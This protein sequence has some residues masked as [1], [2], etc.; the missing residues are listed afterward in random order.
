MAEPRYSGFYHSEER[1]TIGHV[2]TVFSFKDFRWQK[3]DDTYS[4]PAGALQVAF[5]VDIG[6]VIATLSSKRDDLGKGLLPRSLL[7]GMLREAEKYITLNLEHYQGDI[8]Y[9]FDFRKGAVSLGQPLEFLV[10]KYICAQ[11]E[12]FDQ[13][14]DKVKLYAA[15]R[16]NTQQLSGKFHLNYLRIHHDHV[17]RSY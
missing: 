15:R 10:G 7:P 2:V 5:S 14:Q 12:I 8:S 13:W 4:I 9:D 16:K 6:D 17:K 3:I 1:H 11:D